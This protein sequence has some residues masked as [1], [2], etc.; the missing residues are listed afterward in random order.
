MVTA[1]ADV[2]GAR[3]ISSDTIT[4][5]S[6][7]NAAVVTSIRTSPALGRSWIPEKPRTRK[8]PAPRITPPTAP[9]SAGISAS[10]IN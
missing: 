6:A 5:A 1:P 10:I 8:I 4:D 2:A 3:P 7:T 9:R